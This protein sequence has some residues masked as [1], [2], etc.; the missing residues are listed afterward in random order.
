M[1]DEKIYI[2]EEYFENAWNAKWKKMKLS[3]QIDENQKIKV[4]GFL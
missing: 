3:L 4:T 1:R 2:F